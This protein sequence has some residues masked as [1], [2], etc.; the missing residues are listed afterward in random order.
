MAAPYRPYRSRVMPLMLALLLAIFFAV[1]F[2][3]TW[4]DTRVR[5]APPPPEPEPV[6]EVPAPAPAPAKPAPRSGPVTLR[7][8]IADN[9]PAVY[10]HDAC[11][12]GMRLERDIAVADMSAETQA[13]RRA[14]E[15]CAAAKGRQ[16]IEMAKLGT[17][18]LGSDV[19]LWNDYVA[20]ECAAYTAAAGPAR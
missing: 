19:R 8:C 20:R 11:P 18:R 7:K 9:V 15:H 5:P 3:S 12:P 13:L 2:F 14:R 6:A 4:V 10:T 16:R 17:R 1:L